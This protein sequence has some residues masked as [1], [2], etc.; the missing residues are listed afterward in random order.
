MEKTQIEDYIKKLIDIEKRLSTEDD[1]FI[2]DDKS[3]LMAD[4]SNLMN[5]LG[6]DIEVMTKETIGLNV[7]IKRLHPNAVF[8]TY[9][10]DGDAGMDLT[11][12]SVIDTSDKTITYGFGVAMEIPKGYVGLIFPR[13]S[14]KKMDLILSN[15]V[16]VIDSNYRGEIMAAFKTTTSNP[17]V[18]HVGE[19]AAQIIIL[20]YPRV[21]FVEVEELSETGRGQGGYGSTGA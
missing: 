8:P 10:I 13:S 9:S 14:V 1:D 2:V 17:S 6:G 4:L 16:G 3:D 15:C 19:R 11:I 7:N 21:K 12:T 5:S 20:P 18:Y